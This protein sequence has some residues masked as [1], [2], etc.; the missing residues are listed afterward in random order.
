MWKGGFE[1][2]MDTNGHE[3]ARMGTNGH[4]WARMGTNEVVGAGMNVKGGGGEPRIDTN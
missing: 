3:W 4:E 1:P 2:R